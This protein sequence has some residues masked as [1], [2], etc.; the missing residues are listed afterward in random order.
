MPVVSPDQIATA[1]KQHA[2]AK[3]MKRQ[4]EDFEQEARKVILA[5][6]EQSPGDFFPDPKSKTGRTYLIV[7]DG[8]RASIS[9]PESQP[10]PAHFDADKT[11]AFRSKLLD[12]WGEE[13]AE[14]YFDTKYVFREHR[15]FEDMR[16]APGD[17][18][19]EMHTLVEGCVLPTQP[20]VAQSPRVSSDEVS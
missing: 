15:Y 3:A 4:A 11:V 6:Y 10:I 8:F 16:D 19:L 17:K 20:G 5:Y 1:I 7:R 18:K 9:F 12:V 13:R 14:S 2:K